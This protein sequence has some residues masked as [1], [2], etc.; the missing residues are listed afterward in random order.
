MRCDGPGVVPIAAVVS[1]SPGVAGVV[2]PGGSSTARL[3]CA[4]V[5][6]GVPRERVDVAL[7][8]RPVVDPG[9]TAVRRAHEAAEL[10]ADEQQVALVRT[11]RDPADM[12]G[13]WSRRKGPRGAGRQLEE[14]VERAPGVAAVVAAEQAARLAAGVDGAV[15]GRHGDREDAR[16]GQLHVV[17][18]L[19]AVARPPKAML[20]EPREGR[21]PVGGV[22]GQALR[23]ASGE[24]NGHVP[25]AVRLVDP[26]DRVAR[27]GPEPQGAQNVKS[28]IPPDTFSSTP[29]M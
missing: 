18:C 6:L 24:R 13:P 29:V 2:A 20:T 3:V 14:R 10:D 16:L 25:G 21:V 7:R 17:P 11:G 1:R 27:C 4:S 22:S 15:R 26:R 9:L 23:A 12:R 8:A 19:P 28:S 5:R